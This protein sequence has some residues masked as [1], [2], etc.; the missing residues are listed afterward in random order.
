MGAARGAPLQFFSPYPC[1]WGCLLHTV[2]CERALSSCL[3]PTFPS[4]E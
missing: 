2:R 4:K 1:C 3:S